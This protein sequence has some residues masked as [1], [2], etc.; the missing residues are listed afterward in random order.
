MTSTWKQSSRGPDTIL[1]RDEGG[2]AVDVRIEEVRN[3]KGELLRDSE[4]KIITRVHDAR[5]ARPAWP[6]DAA[7]RIKSRVTPRDLETVQVLQ[8]TPKF[9]ALA[10][11]PENAEIGMEFGVRLESIAYGAVFITGFVDAA[12]KRGEKL[13]DDLD[14]EDERYGD[15]VFHDVDTGSII[16]MPTTLDERVEFIRDFDFAVPTFVMGE[17]SRRISRPLAG[18]VRKNT[19]N[20]GSEPTSIRPSKT[21]KAR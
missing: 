4:G 17:I 3:L 14:E 16:E 19:S 21:S 10:S 18:T 15:F 9:R 5:D 6:A 13:P 7:V 8:G 12:S 20:A 1:V 2:D 11:D